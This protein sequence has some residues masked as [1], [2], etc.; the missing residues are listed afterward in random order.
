MYF[1]FDELQYYYV[2]K[3]PILNNMD[4]FQSLN[5]FVIALTNNVLCVGTRSPKQLN[6]LFKVSPHLQKNNI[7]DNWLKFKVT[8]TIILGVT[9]K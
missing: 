1:L 3:L 4:D 6:L 9:I 5:D 7:T 8:S 2:I